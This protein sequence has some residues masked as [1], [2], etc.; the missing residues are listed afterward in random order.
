MGLSA[1]FTLLSTLPLNEEVR[2]EKDRMDNLEEV[3]LSLEKQITGMAE[4]IPPAN[5]ARMAAV[6]HRVNEMMEFTEMTNEQISEAEDVKSLAA[7]S[8]SAIAMLESQLEKVEAE[9]EREKREGETGVTSSRLKKTH[10]K[11]SSHD[12]GSDKPA[13]ISILGHDII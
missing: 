12:G 3:I 10:K 6:C 9:M 7:A 2:T 5:A 1:G 13:A 11:S 4:S 8:A